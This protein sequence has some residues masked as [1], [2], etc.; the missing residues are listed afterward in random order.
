MRVGRYAF[1]GK[2]QYLPL[3]FAVTLKLL[4]KKQQQKKKTALSVSISGFL[5]T[6]NSK[7]FPNVKP[8]IWKLVH[9]ICES[10]LYIKSAL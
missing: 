3:K 2:P 4:F 6:G 8:N 10:V 7:I 9:A 1:H 5:Q